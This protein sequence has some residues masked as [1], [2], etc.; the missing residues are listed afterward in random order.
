[1]A[2]YTPLSLGTAL[3]QT[4]ILL[5]STYY[6]LF[7]TACFGYGTGHINYNIF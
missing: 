1:M 7:L 4:V 6:N 5:G 2:F 3:A